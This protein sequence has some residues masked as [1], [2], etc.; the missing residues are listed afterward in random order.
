M[1]NPA[2]LDAYLAS[3]ADAYY[4]AK[5][6]IISVNPSTIIHADATT[7]PSTHTKAMVWLEASC[8]YQTC[9]H[10]VEVDALGRLHGRLLGRSS[11]TETTPAAIAA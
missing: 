10:Y 4:V 9:F 5:A 11:S 3:Y 8:G 1:S 2:A 6:T 7:S